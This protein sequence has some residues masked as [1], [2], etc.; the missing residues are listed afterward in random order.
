MIDTEAAIQ[1]CSENFTKLQKKSFWNFGPNSII[2]FRNHEAN[3]NSFLSNSDFSLYVS[4]SSSL[5][6]QSFPKQVFP[7]KYNFAENKKT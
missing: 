7:L 3:F 6:C 1:R 2:P 4:E 5:R